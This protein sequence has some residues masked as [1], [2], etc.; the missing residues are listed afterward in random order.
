MLYMIDWAFLKQ[1]KFWIP[2][3]I[4]IILTF[5][6]GFFVG[7]S[8]VIKGDYENYKISFSHLN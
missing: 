2:I 1:P 8:Y 3:L 4:A 7:K 5:F 6:G